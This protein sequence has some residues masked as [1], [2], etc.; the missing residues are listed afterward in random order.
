VLR[1]RLVPRERLLDEAACHVA[2]L[3]FGFVVDSSV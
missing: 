2:D 3:P 1:R